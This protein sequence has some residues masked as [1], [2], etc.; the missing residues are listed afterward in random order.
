MSA[1]R[2]ESLEQAVATLG[3][4]PVPVGDVLADRERVDLLVGFERALAPFCSDP[5]AAALAVAGVRDPERDWLLRDAQRS[6]DQ[7]TALLAERAATNEWVDDAAKALRENQNRFET[8][9]SLCDA[10]EH[11]GIVSGG[12]FTVEAVRRAAAGVPVPK[13]DAIT[14]RIAPTQALQLEDPHDSPLHRSYRVS[15][16]LPVREAEDPARCLRVHEFS[17]RDGWRMV[18]DNCDHGKSADCHQSGGQR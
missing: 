12:W 6:Q 3:A 9:R 8:I 14:Q 1:E 13:P 16:D 18:C 10:A 17:P 2:I 4:L 11:V 5:R 15:H 7:V